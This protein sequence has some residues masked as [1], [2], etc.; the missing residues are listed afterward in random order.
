MICIVAASEIRCGSSPPTPSSS[1]AAVYFALNSASKTFFIAAQNPSCHLNTVFFVTTYGTTSASRQRLKKW[2][3]RSGTLS[4]GLWYVTT[5]LSASVSPRSSISTSA[6]PPSGWK[7]VRTVPA[8]TWAKPAPYSPPTAWRSKSTGRLYPSSI[9]SMWIVSRL[10]VIPFQPRRIA[11][12][13]LPH[14]LHGRGSPS[15]P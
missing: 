15:A 5:A 9:P 8:P 11:P 3:A 13:G 12:F 1:P 10:I 2:R 14:D 7:T 6:P 4:S